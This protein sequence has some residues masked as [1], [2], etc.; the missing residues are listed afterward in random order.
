MPQG[1]SKLNW[2]GSTAGGDSPLGG[3][4]PQAES[5]A[6]SFVATEP[7]VQLTGRRSGA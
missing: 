6:N 2:Q 3:S 4:S 1:I 7:A 5:P